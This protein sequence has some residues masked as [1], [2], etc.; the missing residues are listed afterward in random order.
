MSLIER[1]QKMHIKSLVGS[2]CMLGLLSACG[3]GSSAPPVPA[4]SSVSPVVPTP[5]V[6]TPPPVVPPLPPTATQTMR[7]E[8]ERFHAN[9]G[10][11]GLSLLVVEQDKVETMAI[12]KR[13]MAGTVDVQTSD[14]FQIGSLTKAMSATLIARLVEQKKLRWD[15]TLSEIFPQS[16]ATM[17][18]A[19]VNVTVE[20]LLRHRSGLKRDPDDSDTLILVQR[21]TGVTAT[22]RATAAQ[23]YLQQA[24]AQTPNT[25]FSYSNI[26]YMYIGLIAEAVGGDSYENLM[27]REVFAPLQMKV[28]FVLSDDMGADSPV[29]H[30]AAGSG[31]QV[32][33]KPPAHERVW[34]AI[35]VATGGRTAISMPDYAQFVREQLRGLQGQSTL[36]SK[37][38]Y[39]KLHSP[40]DNYAL[41][42]EI[43]N[44]AAFGLTS[45]HTGSP[46]TFYAST[47]IIPGK[48]R[49]VAIACNCVSD[50]A[51]P[52]INQFVRTIAALKP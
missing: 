40:V 6:V 29:G 38:T 2:L 10:L 48:N 1:H 22:D 19:L 24:P 51:G 39:Q 18:P 20:Q 50:Q 5:P 52:K 4:A 16:R 33:P 37:E 32:A 47:L 11:P 26:G 21:M 35:K 43:E 9:S 27:A 15:S 12:G 8:L 30:I 44:T 3:G 14:Q 25:G 34:Q 13:S 45:F 23:Y 49:A 7:A 36:L 42:W 28:R 17:H 41:G 46:G 31:W